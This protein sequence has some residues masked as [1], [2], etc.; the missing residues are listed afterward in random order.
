LRAPKRDENKG[1]S[2]S[3]KGRGRGAIDAGRSF[4]SSI[5]EEKRKKRRRRKERYEKIRRDSAGEIKER[6]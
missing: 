5:A 1:S 2:G 6:G 3:K 4:L